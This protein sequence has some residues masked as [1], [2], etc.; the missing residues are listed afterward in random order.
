MP[1]KRRAIGRITPVAK[2]KRQSSVN[3]ENREGEEELEVNQE[4][5]EDQPA[6]DTLSRNPPAFTYNDADLSFD[7]TCS[8]GQMTNVCNHCRATKLQG[9]TKSICCGNGKH[10]LDP[11][12]PLPP[13]IKDLF[14]G[15]SPDSEHF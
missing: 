1:P 15:N 3:T 9:E 8:I 6:I 12:P 13:E 2:R 7:S 14:M 5:E 10:K 11:Y 4:E